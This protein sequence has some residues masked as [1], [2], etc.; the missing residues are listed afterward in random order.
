MAQDK[1]FKIRDLRK[2][3]QYKIDDAYLNGYAKLCGWQATLVYNSLSRHADFE[4][5]EAWPSID[6]IADQHDVSRP[7]IIKGIKALEKWNIIS[8]KKEKDNITKR[9]KNNVYFLLDKSVWVAKNNSTR[10]ND[11]DSEPSK[12]GV[13][14]RVNDVDCKDNTMKDNTILS[15]ATEG[16]FNF[17]EELLKLKEN[18]RKDF[19]IIALYWKKKNW[20]FENREQFNAALT[21]ELK[22]AKALKGYSGEQIAKA[23]GYCAK[24]YPEVYTLETV[25][26]RIT[27]MVNKK[28]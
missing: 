17:Q 15:Q 20:V 28:I 24:E 23:V 13:Q 14:S 7:T 26:K 19:K 25:H 3:D 22:A 16:V 1:H 27:D 6:L 4:S 10:V 21:R 8:C 11:I 12:R 9:Q 5:Q 2:K 18:K